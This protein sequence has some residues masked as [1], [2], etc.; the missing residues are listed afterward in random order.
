MRTARPLLLAAFAL[1]GASLAS[2]P[3]AACTWQPITCIGNSYDCN[4]G[5]AERLAREKYWSA[6]A[7]RQRLTEARKRLRAGGVDFAAELSELLV[8]NVRPVYIE[9]S[10]CGPMGEIDHGEGRET[11]ES[12][13]RAL[14]A[15]TPLAGAD[16]ERFRTLLRRTE[17][18]LSFGASCNAEFRRGFAGWLRKSLAPSELRE[19]WIFLGARQRSHGAYGSL[20]HR[21]VTFEGKARTPPIRWYP[22]DRWLGGQVATALRRTAWGRSLSSTIDAFWAGRAGDLADSAKVCPAEYARWAGVRERL[23]PR[24]IEWQAAQSLPV[25]KP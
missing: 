24:L 9:A 25:R 3:A 21:L 1:S 5:A 17:E 19:A 15:G 10:M 18:D 11:E 16:F 12:A 4:P 14:T 20:Y 8:P 6:Y 2:T 13:F 22:A 23:L 7:T